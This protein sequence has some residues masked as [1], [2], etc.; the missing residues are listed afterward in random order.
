MEAEKEEG[1]EGTE[2]EKE[3]GMEGTE[4]EKEED[5]CGPSSEGS[6]ENLQL[7]IHQLHFFSMLFD[8]SLLNGLKFLSLS[9]SFN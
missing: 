6:R 8:L 5:S 7:S 9:C 3:E 2:A 4:A 1:M